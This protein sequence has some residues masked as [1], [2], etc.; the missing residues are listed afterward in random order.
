VRWP[1]PVG[2]TSPRGHGRDFRSAE[3]SA[4]RLASLLRM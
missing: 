2:C 1:Y 3:P 4:W